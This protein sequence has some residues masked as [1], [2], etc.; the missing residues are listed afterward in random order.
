MEL[1]GGNSHAGMA[2]G[3]SGAARVLVA[4]GQ[5]ELVPLKAQA[6]LIY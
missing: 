6:L 2:G 4:L 3:G 1:L 5:K